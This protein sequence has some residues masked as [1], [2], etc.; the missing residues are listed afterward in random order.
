MPQPSLEVTIYKGQIRIQ[1]HQHNPTTPTSTL[2]LY[3]PED[4]L[5]LA[6]SL[7]VKANALSKTKPKR[8]FDSVDYKKD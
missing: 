4:A 8:H 6:Q 1:T 5:F 7:I 2:T 3:T